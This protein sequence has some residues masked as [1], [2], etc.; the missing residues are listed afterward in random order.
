MRA[1]LA[2]FG[3]GLLALIVRGA[4]AGF[5]PSVW[6]PDVGL[7]VVLAIG[8]TRAGARGLILSAALGYTADVLAGSLFGQ[9]A[10]LWI[11]AFAATRVAA[12]QLDLRRLLPFAVFAAGITA[13]DGAGLVMATR[14]F[15]G[16][17]SIDT[18]F[19]GDLA[20][21]VGVNAFVAPLVR[22]LAWGILEAIGVDERARRPL[23]F[24]P[25]RHAG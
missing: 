7:L 2:L 15:A 3:L 20:A 14:F 5:F 18:R 8:V 24:Q 10:L 19:L 17:A 12:R 13:L 4:A 6:L 21:Q 16:T 1:D 9:H 25:G 23:W 11:L 22:A